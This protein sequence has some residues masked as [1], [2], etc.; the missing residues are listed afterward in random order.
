M[1]SE[2][3]QVTEDHMS[4]N[5]IFTVGDSQELWGSHPTTRFSRCTVKLHDLMFVTLVPDLSTALF[6]PGEC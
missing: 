4:C 5:Q 2:Q 3:S 6:F 1:G